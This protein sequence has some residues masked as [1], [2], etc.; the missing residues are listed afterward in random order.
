MKRVTQLALLALAGALIASCTSQSVTPSSAAMPQSSAMRFGR[1]ASA[2][3][4]LYVSNADSEVT[5]YTYPGGTLQTVLTGFEKPMG[6]CT[7]KAGDVYITDA[8]AQT[9]VEYAHGGTTPIQTLDDAP[10]DPYACSVDPKSGALA[11]ADNNGYYEE[12]DIAIWAHATGTPTRYTDPALYQATGCVYDSRGN[13]LASGVPQGSSYAAHFAWM[14]HG[15]AKFTNLIVP[16][17]YTDR[18]F[19]AVGIGWDGQYF[20]IDDYSVYRI[21]VTHGLAY[22]A[23]RVSLTYPEGSGEGGPFA[24]YYQHGKATAVVAG[25]SSDEQSYGQGVAIWN[26]P[27]GGDATAT[28][29]HGLD[30][31]FGVA[32][33]V[34][35]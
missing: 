18:G 14:P 16:G 26:Y 15:S 5:V 22:Y 20:T 17:P 1:Q 24:F 10:D 6:L 7:D 13:L 30:K 29:T 9:I 35:K 32:I 25:I 27:A 33:S 12:G 3:A 21:L 28:I 8:T 23:G 19:Y 11:V 2:A 34:A 4:L 31:P